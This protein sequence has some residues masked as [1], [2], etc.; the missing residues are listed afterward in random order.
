MKKCQASNI[1]KDEPIQPLDVNDGKNTKFDW[2]WIR[3]CFRHQHPGAQWACLFST[4]TNELILCIFHFIADAN[5]QLQ[6]KKNSQPVSN[7]ISTTNFCKCLNPYPA[8][9]KKIN[10]QPLEALFHYRD[11]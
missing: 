1:R 7:N 8:K 2:V 10:F 5:F 11:P 6:M 9:L 4:L 3:D